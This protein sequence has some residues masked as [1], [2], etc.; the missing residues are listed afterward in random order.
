MQRYF[1]LIKKQKACEMFI[2]KKKV[3]IL[4]PN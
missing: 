3:V 1:T 4:Q 2:S